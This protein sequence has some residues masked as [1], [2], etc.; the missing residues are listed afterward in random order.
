MKYSLSKSKFCSGVQCP[1]MLWLKKNVPEAFDD[2]CM[3]QSVLDTGLAVGDLSMG[4]F[5]DFTEV[6]FGDLSEMIATTGKLMDQETPVIA[7]TPISENL[8]HI[9]LQAL[10][11]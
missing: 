3:N 11:L 8:W 7:F 10:C 9:T 6:P 4:L 2:S 5:G 1:K